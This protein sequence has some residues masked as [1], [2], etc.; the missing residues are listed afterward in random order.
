VPDRNPLEP[1]AAIRQLSQAWNVRDLDALEACFQPDYESAQPL[2]PDRNF[3]GRDGVR[4]C[5]GALMDAMPDFQADLLGWSASADVIWTEWRWH[6]SPVDG[7]SF[8]AGGVMLFGLVDGCL[9]WARVYT[10]TVK[11]VGPDFDRVLEEILSQETRRAV[12]PS[13]ID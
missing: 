7:G 8:T 5:W 6:G 10:E 12:R 11:V 2:H 3:Q 1:P 13:Y 4:R 9:A